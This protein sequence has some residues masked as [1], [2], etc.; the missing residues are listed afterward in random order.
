MVEVFYYCKVCY[1]PSND[2]QG[3]ILGGCPVEYVCECGKTDY[4][5][6]NTIIYDKRVV[7]YTQ[8]NIK[9]KRRKSIGVL[10]S[11]E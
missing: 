2:Q 7:E 1:K 10:L 4:G 8:K 5:S 9:Y 3:V 11:D 6:M